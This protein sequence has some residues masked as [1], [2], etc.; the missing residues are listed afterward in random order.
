MRNTYMTLS[1]ER[2]NLNYTILVT[3]IVIPVL[4]NK[5]NI[6]ERFYVV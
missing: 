5:E 6:N 4:L 2:N 1:I 3:T